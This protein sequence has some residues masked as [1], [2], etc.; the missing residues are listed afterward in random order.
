MMPV[1]QGSVD[2][3]EDDKGE[4]KPERSTHKTKQNTSTPLA[5]TDCAGDAD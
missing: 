4:S 3:E 1:K 2:G 5:M